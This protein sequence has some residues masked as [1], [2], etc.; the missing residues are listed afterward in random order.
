MAI[1]ALEEQDAI[2]SCHHITMKD[3]ISEQE[4]E[5]I[6]QELRQLNN[7]ITMAKME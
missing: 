5:R 2:R 1:K 6:M 4:H 3:N 7:Q